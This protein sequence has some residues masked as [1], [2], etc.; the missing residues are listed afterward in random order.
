VWVKGRGE[1]ND[2]SPGVIVGDYKKWNSWIVDIGGA[3]YH[4]RDSE[5]APRAR[6]GEVS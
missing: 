2:M 5:L 6:L 4:C 1:N 3:T